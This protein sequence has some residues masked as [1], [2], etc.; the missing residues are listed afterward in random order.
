MGAPNDNIGFLLNQ[1]EL[2]NVLRRY[3][4]D[5]AHWTWTI[6]VSRLFDLE[7]L[8]ALERRLLN[9]ASDIAN[10]FRSLYGDTV[11]NRL[12]RVLSEHYYTLIAMSDALAKGD[13][14]TAAVLHQRLYQQL[15]E[16][17]EIL[18]NSNSNI[19][20]AELQILLYDLLSLLEQEAVMI[21]SRQYEESTQQYD[22]VYDQAMRI[23]DY[24]GYAI[25]R[26]IRI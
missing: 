20:K 13:M 8:P 2:S 9:I 26:Q 17:V 11:A 1:V 25:I 19:D 18:G 14:E 7:H 3:W 21:F 15:D 6:F 12:E 23:A 5:Y 24:L 16:V 10:V 4:S 22:M